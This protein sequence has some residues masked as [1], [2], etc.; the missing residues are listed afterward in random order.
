M[1]VNDYRAFDQRY[2]KSVKHRMTLPDAVLAFKVLDNDNLSNHERQLTLTACTDL[3]YQKIQ[4]AMKRILEQNRHSEQNKLR[5]LLAR[6]SNNLQCTLNTEGQMNQ[7]IA[8]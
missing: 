1:N 4:S 8:Q 2:Q 3:S 7:E 6:L 5:V